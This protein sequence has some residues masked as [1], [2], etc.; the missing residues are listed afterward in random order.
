MSSTPSS[1]ARGRS[2]NGAAR[3][4]T[5]SSVVDGPVVHR[6]HGD[7]LLRQHVERVARIAQ[8]LDRA[9]PHALDHDRAFEQV[10]AVLR[11][12]DAAAHGA[13]LVPR[14]PD[15]LQ[16][17]RHR[18]R[19]LHLHHQVDRAHVDPELERATS[20]P[21]RAC[22]RLAA[23]PRSA[24][25]A[26]GSPSR[27]ARAADLLARPAR[28]G[29]RTAARPAAA[30]WR[31]RSWCDARGSA[32]AAAPRRAATRWCAPRR[33]RRAARDAAGA[34]PMRAMSSTGH[35]DR[36]VERLVGR[37]GDDRHRPRA[38]EEPRH[39]LQRPH[40]RRQPDALRR[41]GQQAVEPLERRAPG[42]RRASCRR[43]RAPRR[44]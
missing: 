32:R 24:R 43:P 21:P 33:P 10:A 6:H 15:A 4:T 20:R 40:G 35:D 36:Q 12:E 41:L 27:G 9:R 34:A 3:R 14:P 31:T 13:H 11:E 23:P 25:A 5:R 19:R 18:R 22:A 17:G 29:A 28:S 2:A 39:L 37:R 44:R 26:R 30:S 16:A 7:D 42:A 1:A 8:R 38:A